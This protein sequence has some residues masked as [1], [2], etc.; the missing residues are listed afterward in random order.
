MILRRFWI[1]FSNFLNKLIKRKNRMYVTYQRSTGRDFQLANVFNRIQS[2]TNTQNGQTFSLKYAQNQT[3]FSMMSAENSPHFS[4]TG[5]WCGSDQSSS[6][7]NYASEHCDWSP[8]NDSKEASHLALKVISNRWLAMRSFAH[9]LAWAS[10]ARHELVSGGSAKH[11]RT[12]RI[13]ACGLK[14]WCTLSTLYFHTNLHYD[15]YFF[16]FGIRLRNFIRENGK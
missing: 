12:G 1:Q 3:H 5:C 7:S 2:R 16:S 10:D 15:C 11:L 4:R 9:K 14:R 13:R 8:L 6:R